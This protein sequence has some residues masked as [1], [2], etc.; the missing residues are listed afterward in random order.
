MPS[1]DARG[2]QCLVFGVGPHG[3]DAGG[4]F[5]DQPCNVELF[6]KERHLARLDLREVEDVVDEGELVPGRAV[7]LLEVRYHGGGPNFR[8]FLFHHLA[9]ADDGVERG[10]QLVAHVRQ[11][12]RLRAVGNIGGFP[13]LLRVFAGGFKL[14]VLS[15]QRLRRRLGGFLGLFQL[16]VGGGELPRQMDR[17][18]GNQHYDC[19]GE[20]EAEA[21]IPR[22]TP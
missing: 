5:V 2:G 3:P 6:H 1:L 8:G 13:V 14:E 17:R 7:D 4:D 16:A 22:I 19:A 12:L 11:E 10:A 20:R 15:G 9:V 18:K 21:K